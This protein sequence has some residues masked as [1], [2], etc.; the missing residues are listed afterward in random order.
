MRTT[1]FEVATVVRDF[2]WSAE[3]NPWSRARVSSASAG[4]L[5]TEIGA[6]A[7]V[8]HQI[9]DVSNLPAD[10]ARAYCVAKSCIVAASTFVAVAVALVVPDV[11]PS[12]AGALGLRVCVVALPP[13]AANMEKLA[14]NIAYAPKDSRCTD[15]TGTLLIARSFI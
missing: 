12:E 6:D 2:T 8:R 10:F 5:D 7:M 11:F 14:I 15:R 3:S 13:H 9:P 4:A 1:R